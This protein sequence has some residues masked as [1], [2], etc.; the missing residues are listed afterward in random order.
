MVN[1]QLNLIRIIYPQETKNTLRTPDLGSR[2]GSAIGHAQ[3]SFLSLFDLGFREALRT[4]HINALIEPGVR[5]WSSL[6]HQSN[7]FG[8]VEGISG[9]AGNLRTCE[10]WNQ[11]RGK[12]EAA[13]L[14]D[15]RC[16]H[17]FGNLKKL[18]FS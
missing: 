4:E 11:E 6:L 2:E 13:G 14:C 15:R 12:Q 1:Q 18:T 8:V 16:M 17:H 7:C 5:S 9:I 10:D 3:A